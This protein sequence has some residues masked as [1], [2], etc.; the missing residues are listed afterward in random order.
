MATSLTFSHKGET[1]V[2]GT[3]AGQL[4][5]WDVESGELTKTLTASNR[6]IF[7]LAFLPDNKTLAVSSGGVSLWDIE[8]GE[9]RFQ[10]A[11]KAI[12]PIALSS[13]GRT[14]AFTTLVEESDRHVPVIGF[15]HTAQDDEVRSR[16]EGLRP[17]VGRHCS[18]VPMVNRLIDELETVEK[19]VEAL[20]ADDTLDDP[21][22]VLSLRLAGEL[23]IFRKQEKRVR[24]LFEE[25]F[26]APPVR[27]IIERDTTLD[28]EERR[29]AI[30]LTHDLAPEASA[31]NT[32]S[33]N[34]VERSD[35]TA[36][37]YARALRMARAACELEPDRHAYFNTLGVALYRNG[38]YSGGVQILQQADALNLSSKLPRSRTGIWFS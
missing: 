14:I 12:P 13:D 31:L 34:V 10:F 7:E 20:D 21:Q 19:V 27:E 1:L 5:V 17:G 3:L 29:I 22:R 33:W 4:L 38:T 24:Q 32:K 8:R 23:V 37:E 2:A 6:E 28:E 11:E 15:W 16:L 26:V 9:P 18:P 25:H 30:E 36:E 35:A